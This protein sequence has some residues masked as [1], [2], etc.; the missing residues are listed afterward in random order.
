[1]NTL[2]RFWGQKKRLRPLGGRACPLLV[3]KLVCDLG[4]IDCE[5]QSVQV[6]ILL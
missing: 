3:Y 1:M 4:I 2:H 5:N 6:P